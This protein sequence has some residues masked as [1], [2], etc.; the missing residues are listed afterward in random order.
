MERQQSTSQRKVQRQV[1]YAAMRDRGSD[2]DGNMEQLEVKHSR[3]VKQDEDLP[4]DRNQK[5]LVDMK[6]L[7]TFRDPVVGPEPTDDL[8]EVFEMLSTEELEHMEPEEVLKR[9]QCPFMLRKENVQFGP[10]SSN[11]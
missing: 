5:V 2:S 1:S 10:V 3:E 11:N 7:P 4:Q 6:S 8:P 9:L